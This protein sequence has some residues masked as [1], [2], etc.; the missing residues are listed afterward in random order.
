MVAG[1][2]LFPD[3]VN[4]EFIWGWGSVISRTRCTHFHTHC[5]HSASYPSTPVL[6]SWSVCFQL[7][8]V[9]T[10]SPLRTCKLTCSLQ[11]PQE[12]STYSLYS[13]G[14]R[15]SQGRMIQR[16]YLVV[17]TVGHSAT[18]WHSSGSEKLIQRYLLAKSTA[19]TKESHVSSKY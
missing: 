3:W 15:K 8:R 13:N 17:N 12:V 18:R 4:S 5:C 1:R 9:S 16:K 11:L 19:K 6:K 7:S 10:I 14:R 2:P